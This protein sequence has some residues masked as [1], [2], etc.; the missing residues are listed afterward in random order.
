MLSSTHTRTHETF[1][2]NLKKKV[3]GGEG[4]VRVL[5]TSSL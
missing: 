4:E 2:V 3:V 5:L 1:C